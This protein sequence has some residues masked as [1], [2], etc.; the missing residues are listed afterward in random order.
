MIYC[1]HLRAQKNNRE[2]PSMPR[3]LQSIEIMQFMSWSYQSYIKT[4]RYI[5][6]LITIKMSSEDIVSKE[7]I[8]EKP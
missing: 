5:I 1:E 6:D 4:P 3:E 7:K 8:A 2:G